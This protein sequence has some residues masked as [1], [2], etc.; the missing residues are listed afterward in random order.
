MEGHA[1]VYDLTQDRIGLAESYNCKPKQGLSGFVDDDMFA[2]PTI[3]IVTETG[4][5]VDNA[6]NNP[7][8]PS[9]VTPK[10]ETMG[11]QQQQDAYFGTCV[12]AT[13]ISFVTVG[14][15]IVVVALVVA[16]KKYKPRNLSKKWDSEE[17]SGP[18]DITYDGRES[19]VLNP[20]FERHVRHV[21]A[22]GFA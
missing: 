22:D 13:C 20:D 12:T 2:L 4:A 16:Y 17:A 19:E 11:D 7:Y 3:Q 5:V 15:V 21:E 6:G 10:M 14:Y 8:S 18:D 1:F 9:V